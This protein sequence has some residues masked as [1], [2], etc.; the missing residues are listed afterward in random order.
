M[1]ILIQNIPRCIY[2]D[3]LLGINGLLIIDTTNDRLKFCCVVCYKLEYNNK[4]MTI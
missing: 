3:N 4:E 1:S 2:C